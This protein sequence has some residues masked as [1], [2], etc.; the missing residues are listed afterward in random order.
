[1]KILVT[2]G[3]G[4]IG[5]HIVDALLS[6]GHS[7]AVVD[8]LSTGFTTNLATDARFYQMD[9]RDAGL[10]EVF[11][12]ES[13]EVVCHQAA[14]ANVRESMQEPVLYADVNILGSLN[15]LECCRRSG[16]RK[17]I[18]ASTGGAVYGEPEILPVP[19]DH[20]VNPLDPYGTSKHTVEH[21]LYLYRANF[22]LE[23]TALRYPNVFGPRQN[24]HGEAGVVAIFANLM[25]QGLPVL[26][27]GDG[28]QERDFVH[29]SD[30][31]SANL[32]ALQKGDGEICNIGRGA[33][34][35]VNRI[36]DLLVQLTDYQLAPQHGPAK[37]GEVSRIWLDPTLAWERLNWKTRLSLEDG[38][39]STIEF[40]R[41]KVR[42]NP[43]P[44]DLASV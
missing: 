5:S 32:L 30:V 14:R 37:Q 28:S 41:E 9:I 2:G 1:M 42:T 11:E 26:I 6:A 20:P 4:F 29:V 25:L 21:Y 16:V 7:V 43:R 3:A 15:L 39:R 44:L 24:P 10:G 12:A 36:F 27:N 19:E 40:F 31:V 18:Y 23:Y 33:G 13:P 22:G 35:S 17:V 8:D 38:L 34:V